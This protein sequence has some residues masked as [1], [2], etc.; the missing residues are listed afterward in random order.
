[1]VAIMA[2]QPYIEMIR[3]KGEHFVF[4][5]RNALRHA[6]YYS[7]FGS[8]CTNDSQLYNMHLMYSRI[9]ESSMD[10]S[11]NGQNE[12]AMKVSQANLSGQGCHAKIYKLVNGE[13]ILASQNNGNS[14][15]FEFAILYKVPKPEF[16]EF[17]SKTFERCAQMRQWF[18]KNKVF[19]G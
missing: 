1:M 10:W 2:Q 17:I 5:G 6:I 4:T 15:L 12:T 19:K 16:K 8:M 13:I 9:I 7:Y 18:S 14:P 11:L 3:N